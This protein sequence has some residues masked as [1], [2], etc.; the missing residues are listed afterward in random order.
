MWLCSNK[1]SHFH[2]F[3]WDYN[4]CQATVISHDDKQVMSVK[5]RKKKLK[6]NNE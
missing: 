5:R 6:Y 4:L 1:R 3:L 2:L